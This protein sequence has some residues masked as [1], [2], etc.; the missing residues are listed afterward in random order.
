MKKTYY[1]LLN[2]QP[3]ATTK[4]VQAVFRRIAARYRPTITV[5]QIFT[6]AHFHDY[7]NAYLTLQGESRAKYDTLLT[8]KGI[9]PKPLDSLAARERGMLMARIAYWRREMLEAH[10]SIALAGTG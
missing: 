7:V 10:A 1:E 6:D 4:E 9:P 2:I 3:T 8:S 5:E